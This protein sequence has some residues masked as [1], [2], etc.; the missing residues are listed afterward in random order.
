[1]H[2]SRFILIVVVAFAA[3]QADDR[4]MP[5]SS[6]SSGGSFEA[7]PPLSGTT[8]SGSDF[9]LDEVRGQPV[10]LVFYRGAFC[11][12]CQR[13]LLQLAAHREAYEQLGGRVIAVTLDD[14]E[15]ADETI[16]ELDID[17]AV[18]SVAPSTFE[19]WGAWPEDESWPRPAAFVLDRDGRIRYHHIGSNASDRTTDVV[20][21]GILAATEEPAASAVEPAGVGS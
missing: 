3:C 19:S 9:E 17:L 7:A 21:L 12:L 13:R 10:V 8:A 1:M 18:V 20:L 11:N 6:A 16:D 5:E 2:G 14:P 15:T 4:Q